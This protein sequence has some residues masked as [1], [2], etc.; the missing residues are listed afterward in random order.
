MKIVLTAIAVGLLAVGAASAQDS[1]KLKNGDVVSGSLVAYDGTALVMKTPYNKALNVD[2]GE[3]VGVDTQQPM[4]VVLKS[5]EVI[6]GRLV[7]KDG[8]VY[9]DGPGG[10]AVQPA[11]IETIGVP[12]VAWSGLAG[13]TILGATGN[14]RSLALGAKTEVQ[15]LT[16]VDR[17]TVS[18]RADY[19]E[20]D[21][22]SSVQTAFGRIRLEHQ[23]TDA[24]F[25]GVFDEIEHD[26]FKNIRYRNR[27]GVGPGYRF[28]NTPTMLL[29]AMVGIAYTY[30]DYRNQKDEG[31]PSAVGN[32]EFRWKLSDSQTMYELFDIYPSLEHG[33]DFTFRGEA[34]F[35]QTITDGIVLDL[36][37][38]DDY[39]HEPAPGSKT[40]D[41]RYQ[42]SV[43]YIW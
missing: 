6:E 26:F 17:F 28:I 19:Q 20:I 35:R 27:I 37:F 3:V 12:E 42:L 14:T 16:K 40:N 39:N 10:H 25:V 31:A 21:K 41:F 43:G 13:V 7:S 22:K 36:G 1:V 9:I 30:T 2:W 15:R 11:D 8:G 24:W 18:G 32:Q 23:L 33:S 29:S 4:R 38:V 5:G 34:G